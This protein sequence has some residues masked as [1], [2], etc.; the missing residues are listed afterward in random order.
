VAA[1]GLAFGDTSTS[2]MTDIALISAYRLVMFS[3]A[4]LALI[5]G[6]IA[7]LTIHRPQTGV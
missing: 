3:A 6:L 1:L 4:G 7:A 2:S 5:G